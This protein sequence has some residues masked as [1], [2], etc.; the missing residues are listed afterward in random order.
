M[1]SSHN[2]SANHSDGVDRD[3]HGN[4]TLNTTKTPELQSPEQL[5]R[6]AD[7][8]ACGGLPLP[9]DLHPDLLE[10]LAHEVRQRRHR[11]LVS[12]I[13]RAIAKDIFRSRE[14]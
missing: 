7:L 5:A 3:C 14:P 8:V 13:A 12:F 2:P 1:P 6:L 4:R 9:V 11:R 10:H